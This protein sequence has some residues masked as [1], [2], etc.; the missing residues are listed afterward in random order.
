MKRTSPREENSTYTCAT[1]PLLKDL[2]GRHWGILEFQIN[3]YEAW[4]LILV[5]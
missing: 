5:V 2:N 3:P 1:K 4:V